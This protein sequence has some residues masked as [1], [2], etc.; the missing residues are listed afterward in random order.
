[1]KLIGEVT[2]LSKNFTPQKMLVLYLV[3]G[4]LFLFLVVRHLNVSSQIKCVALCLCPKK[5]L[6][7]LNIERET[8]KQL[9]G[10]HNRVR[11]WEGE[12]VSLLER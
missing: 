3:Y 2:I 5:S 4:L 12:N 6:Q 10:K 7:H 11:P 1:M 9:H 8:P